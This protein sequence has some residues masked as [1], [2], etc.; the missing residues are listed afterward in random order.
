MNLA[1]LIGT[2]KDIS[3][4]LSTLLPDDWDIWT[5]EERRDFW[6]GDRHGGSAL[7]QRVC[8]K[9]IWM[10]LCCGAADRFG[11]CIAQEINKK[12][13]E[14]SPYWRGRSSVDCG[15]LYGRQRGFI[16]DLAAE[17]IDAM[18]KQVANG[19]N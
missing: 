3:E 8:A 2:E 1:E 6:A 9:E 18:T 11:S 14:A 10:E 16:Y 7:R 19:K 5:L 13:R 4:Y 17:K 12:I 15:P